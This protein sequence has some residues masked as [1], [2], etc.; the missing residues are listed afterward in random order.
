MD[1]LIEL[2]K[3]NKDYFFNSVTY[4]MLT[5]TANKGRHAMILSCLSTCNYKLLEELLED[6]W[7]KKPLEGVIY[8]MECDFDTKTLFIEAFR[9]I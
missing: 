4:R 1:K 7:Y 3:L 2:I 5:S 6:V 8:C 9:E